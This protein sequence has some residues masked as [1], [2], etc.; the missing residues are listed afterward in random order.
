[1]PLHIFVSTWLGTTLGVLEFAKI[2]KDILLIVGFAL[3]LTVSKRDHLKQLIND[4]LTWVITGYFTITLLLAFVLKTDTDAEILAI[5]Y[6]LRFLVFFLYARLL[7][8]G[9]GKQVIT[10]SLKIV[11][12]VGFIVALIAVLQY[13]VIPD[14][15]LRHFGYQKDPGVLPV[16]YIDNKIGY[17]RVMSTIRDPNSLGSYLI[18]TF[19]MFTALLLRAK[20]QSRLIL[21][22]L[23]SITGLAL[24]LT[25]SR[26]AW[27]GAFLSLV[28]VIL[29]SKSAREYINKQKKILSTLALVLIVGALSTVF[30]LRNDSAFQNIF[31]HADE[32]TVLEDPN[33]KR[34]RYLEESINEIISKPV[35]HGPGTAGLPSI[36]NEKQGTVLNENYYTQIAYEVGLVGLGLF[37][38]ILS[39]VFLRFWPNRFE[40]YNSFLIASFIGLAFTNLLVHIWSNEAVA[41]TWW[42]LAGLVVGLNLKKPK[43][44]IAKT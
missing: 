23:S 11:G 8:A 39:V 33:Q 44:K 17:E 9:F 19:A 16:F 35:G 4:K 25:F 12:A 10:T 2:G 13:T 14:D 31:F 1:M 41:Y 18:I 15:F 43:P 3:M 27:I 26:S 7:L 6:N 32:K 28:T 34:A 21:L 22:G 40:Y 29:L 36:R 5:V 37:L 30:L 38:I 42:G 20:K 24:L